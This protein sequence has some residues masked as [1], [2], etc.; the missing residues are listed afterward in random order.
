MARPATKESLVRAFYQTLTQA[1]GPQH[2][3]PAQTRF[4]VIVGAYLTQNTAWTNV[5]HTLAN[6]RRANLLTTAGVRRVSLAELEQ[7]V[8]PAGYFRQKA[9]RLK[10]FLEFLDTQYGGSL[11]RMFAQHTFQLREELL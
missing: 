2:W 4:E 9:R 1:W 11:N 6:L 3:W 10:T 5:E 8:R 7:L